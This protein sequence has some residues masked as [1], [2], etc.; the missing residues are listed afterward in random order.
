MA[1]L[2][3][4][5]VGYFLIALVVAGVLWYLARTARNKS[6]SINTAGN[7]TKHIDSRD[8]ARPP[9]NREIYS[10]IRFKYRDSDG[11][12]TERTVDVLSGKRG[13][14]FKGYC[15]LRKDTRTF[16]FDR[17]EGD[18]VVDI[19]TGEV[20]TP[21]AWRNKLQGTSVSQD[22]LADE[23]RRIAYKQEL[24]EANNTWLTLTMPPPVVEF[25]DKRFALGG[26]FE[27]GNIDA[28]KEKVLQRGGIIQASPN[29]KTNYIVV[30]PKAGVNET[31][32]NAIHKLREKNI[33]PTIISEAHWLESIETNHIRT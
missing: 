21:M 7:Q 3:R 28:S 6:P 14:E 2:V 15:H 17:I 13:Y 32:K 33:Q 31:Y 19:S 5:N 23:S 16:Y 20:M 24:E 22:A 26:Y 1:E 8:K 29:G 10:S 9:K 12:I 11:N 4:I 25:K 27:S 30:N 18:E